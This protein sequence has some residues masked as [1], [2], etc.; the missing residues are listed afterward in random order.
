VDALSK[1]KETDEVPASDQYPSKYKSIM[2]TDVS[3][4]V[5]S[6]LEYS[7]AQ[8]LNRTYV[9]LPVYCALPRTHLYSSIVLPVLATVISIF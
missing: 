9:L 1:F 6:K 4:I 5:R 2:T 8:L 7:R 3:F